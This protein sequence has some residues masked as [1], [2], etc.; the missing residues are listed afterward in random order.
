MLF[1]PQRHER[2]A[3]TAW[4]ADRARE[5][6]RDIAADT[7][8]AMQ[9]GVAWPWHPLDADGTSEPPHRSLYLGAAGVLWALWALERSGLVAL[10][11]PPAAHVGRLHDA[12][13]AQP[14]TGS[15]VPSYFLGEAGILLVQWRLTDP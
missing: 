11:S 3:D 15:P 9:S 6:I 1:E 7:E 5:A 8:A 10:R 14:D 13:L 2:L 4:N 12:Y